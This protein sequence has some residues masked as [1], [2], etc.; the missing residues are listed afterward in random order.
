MKAKNISVG[1]IDLGNGSLQVWGTSFNIK[2]SIPSK[3]GVIS[4][5]DHRKIENKII[6]AI[7]SID[8]ED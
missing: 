6:A 1:V 5:A 7:E 8:F 2:G 4:K 3:D